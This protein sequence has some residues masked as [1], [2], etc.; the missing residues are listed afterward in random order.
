[1]RHTCPLYFFLFLFFFFFS[2]LIACFCCV[3][4]PAVEAQA[5]QNPEAQADQNT[6]TT[7]AYDPTFRN[8]SPVNTHPL[9]PET[10]TPNIHAI[11]EQDPADFDHFH[12]TASHRKTNNIIPHA[13]FDHDQSINHLYFDTVHF[14]HHIVSSTNLHHIVSNTN[15]DNFVY[16]PLCPNTVTN[17]N[18]TSMT[19][20]PD[21]TT[22]PVLDYSIHEHLGPTNPETS[23][24][25][26][27][28]PDH[29]LYPPPIC[30]HKVWEV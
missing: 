15:R 5:D 27:P 18:H 1:M 7:A 3:E 6:Y 22:V 24:L 28:I 20:H 8:P 13:S 30:F 2:F 19:Q 21:I 29:L 25:G 12:A 4:V 11:P 26:T 14:Y 16:T 23:P 17:T 9:P 10:P